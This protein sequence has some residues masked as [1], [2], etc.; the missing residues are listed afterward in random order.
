MGKSYVDSR[1]LLHIHWEPKQRE[2]R[3]WKGQLNKGNRKACSLCRLW[4]FFLLPCFLVRGPRPTWPF[5][6]CSAD[7]SIWYPTPHPDCEQSYFPQRLS[8]PKMESQITNGGGCCQ[9]QYTVLNTYWILSFSLNLVTWHARQS[10]ETWG[11]AWIEASS[12]S[13]LAHILLS[14]SMWLDMFSL[15]GTG[16]N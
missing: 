5:Q 1:P 4:Y 12:M 11:K 3:V 9:R 8:C 6:I 16:H 10:H 13:V 14:Y 7:Q 2:G 15:N